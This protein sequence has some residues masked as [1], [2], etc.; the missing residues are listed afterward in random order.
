LQFKEMTRRTR[1]PSAAAKGIPGSGCVFHERSSIGVSSEKI[2]IVASHSPATARANRCFVNNQA[3]PAIP[4][5]NNPHAQNGKTVK[6]AIL[7]H[8]RA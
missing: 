5:P 2:K 3:N 7:S 8:R 6:A 4:I 1:L